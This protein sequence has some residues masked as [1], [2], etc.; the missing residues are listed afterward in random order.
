MKKIYGLAAALLLSAVSFGQ[1]VLS[2]S[3]NTN[4]TPT[5]WT[6]TSKTGGPWV[7]G[8]NTTNS[9]GYDV[10]NVPDHTG[11]NGYYAWVDFSGTDD[12]VVLESPVIDVS[13]LSNIQLKFYFVSYYSGS[14]SPY[15]ILYVEA[16]D[17]SMWVGVDSLQQNNPSAAWVEINENLTAFT[18]AGGDSLRIRFRAES[19]GSSSDYQNDLLIDDIVVSEAPV[20]NLAVIKSYFNDTNLCPGDYVNLH[21]QFYNFSADTILSGSTISMN[22]MSSTQSAN[23]SLTLTSDMLPGDT[24]DYAFTTPFMVQYG[25]NVVTLYLNYSLDNYNLNDTLTFTFNSDA[26]PATSDIAICIGDSATLS[27]NGSGSYIWYDSN[28]NQV[29]TGDQITVGPLTASTTYYVS[30][31]GSKKWFIDTA[32]TTG[33]AVDHNTYT[34]DDRGGI[35]VTR[36]YVYI[37]GDGNMVRY[38]AADM[39]NPV[40]L[41]QND[42]IFSDLFDGQ[43]YAL[44]NTV[45]N[46]YPQGTYISN[47]S[48]NAIVKLDEMLNP[49]DTILLSQQINI[50]SSTNKAGVFAGSGYLILYSGGTNGTFYRIGL[51][52]GNVINLGTYALT[53]LESSENWANWGIADSIAGDYYVIYKPSTSES[54][55]RMNLTTYATQTIQNNYS[56]LGNMHSIT[57]SPWLKRIYF[58]NEYNNDWGSFSEAGGYIEASHIS[59]GVLT[60]YGNCMGEAY[61]EVQN[62][63]V[64]LGPDTVA[65]QGYV[66]DAGPG[67]VNYY[68]S[69]GETTQSITVNGSGAYSVTV[70]TSAGCVAS[71]AVFIIITGIEELA[72]QFGAKV[73]PNPSAGQFT[74]QLPNNRMALQA[75]ITD[76]TGKVV[77]SESLTNQT[78]YTVNLEGTAKGVYF[79]QLT[80]G[81][82]TVTQKLIIK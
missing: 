74:I 52:S 46:S 8:N 28:M 47:D 53:G 1:I 63:Q 7:F 44:F 75:V 78:T 23:E 3:F 2:E 70:V 31:A 33:Y 15:N 79:L 9:P 30:F 66:L 77:Y 11:N 58:H 34:G 54:I 55:E 22:Y 65:N 40:V 32:Y 29:G 62:P 51:P 41:P 64:N 73:Y 20:Y 10:S 81:Q 37:N 72:A 61:V 71:D 6:N 49:I 59:L 27:V 35:A 42:G 76:M 19:G 21:L 13:M 38:N 68:W 36:D 80:D 17:G 14:L 16:W 50:S 26:V 18:Y 60:P 24:L 4:T 45:S 48:I 39:T 57:Y 67:F 25:Q 5:G 82:K 56:D 69:T 12:S 43:L